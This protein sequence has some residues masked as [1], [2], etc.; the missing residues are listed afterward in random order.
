MSFVNNCKKNDSS[1]NNNRYHN[2]MDIEFFLVK[3]VFDIGVRLGI[4]PRV[5]II[6]GTVDCHRIIEEH[7]I[8]QSR[9][10]AVCVD[11]RQFGAVRETVF[12]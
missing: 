1:N 12:S 5:V 8:I 4:V 7:S 10:G 2:M 11:V 9:A 3:I 6:L